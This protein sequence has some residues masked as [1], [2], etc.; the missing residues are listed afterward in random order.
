MRTYKDVKKGEKV[1][2]VFNVGPAHPL[3]QKEIEAIVDFVGGY[4]GRQ[5]HAHTVEE[6][7]HPAEILG[8]IVTIQYFEETKDS[9]TET[10]SL[11]F[12]VLKHVYEGGR[13]V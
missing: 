6:V 5:I 13:T 12:P 1:T 3:H 7:H 10:Y 8:E 9:K 11:R 2:V 4:D